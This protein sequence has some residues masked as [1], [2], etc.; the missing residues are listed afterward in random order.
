M[1]SDFVIRPAEPD[2]AETI[3]ALRKRVDKDKK[4]KYPPLDPY[5]GSYPSVDQQ[6]SEIAESG[7][8]FVALAETQLVGCAYCSELYQSPG[9]YGLGFIVD[10]AW[11]KNGIGTSLALQIVTWAKSNSEVK[12]LVCR[13]ARGD[14]SKKRILKNLDFEIVYEGWVY[15]MQGAMYNSTEMAFQIS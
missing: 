4:N 8:Y 5:G 15:F 12:K 9:E 14:K 3:A 10:P 1:T 6:R 13:F 2:D 7:V 11:R